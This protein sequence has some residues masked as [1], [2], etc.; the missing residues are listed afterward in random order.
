LP[1]GST[2]LRAPPQTTARKHDRPMPR[3]NLPRQNLE[4]ALDEE[5]PEVEAPP[6]L[7]GHRI[8]YSMHMVTQMPHGDHLKEES[9]ARKYLEQ[10]ITHALEHFEDFI[11]HVEVRFLV[12]EHFHRD[13][14]GGHK[15]AIRAKAPKGL[16]DEDIQVWEDLDASSSGPR[17]PAPYQMKVVVSLT[18]HKK[19]VYSNPEKHAQ[20][21][22]TEC[23][24]M[25]VEGLTHLLR[26]EKGK[27]IQK[28]RKSKAE[29]LLESDPSL[30]ALDQIEEA[31][32]EEEAA[33]QMLEMQ[34]A[35]MERIYEAVEDS[36]SS[37]E[38]DASLEAA[39]M[40]QEGVATAAGAAPAAEAT[41]ET[42]KKEQNKK[43]GEDGGNPIK[44]VLDL[45]MR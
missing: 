9:R 24:D 2:S 12:Q 3:A 45:L 22:L 11:R 28:N 42:A 25:A 5:V 23:A 29:A 26:E 13:K 27:M 40:P 39:A 18:N 16:Q 44:G 1:A 7:P 34:D 10:K 35:V 43:P 15:K 31:A 14:A 6:P 33:Q 4:L 32:L 37:D 38:E 41:A 19:V 20:A 30:G 8:P 36:D 17:M 21:T